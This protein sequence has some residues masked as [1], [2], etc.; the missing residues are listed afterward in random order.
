MS[1]KYT[2]EKN[3]LKPGTFYPRPLA[4][5]TYRTGELV[6]NISNATTVTESDVEAVIKALRTQVL[7]HLAD[8][9]RVSIDGVVHFRPRLAQVLH[10]GSGEFD[11][12]SGGE[13][14]VAATVKPAMTKALRAVAGF[15]KLDKGTKAPQPKS[16]LNSATKSIGEYTPGGIAEVSGTNLQIFD[17]QA[18]DEGIFFVAAADG[19]ETRVTDLHR[20][21]DRTLIFL[22]PEALTG[23]QQ[24]E[25][26]TRYTE[27][28][29][30]RA[31]KLFDAV[32]AA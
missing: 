1:I 20:N 31:G 12:Q 7:H 14:F 24:L 3:A 26:R 19:G 27:D 23:Q 11:P 32:S 9:N 8:G 13:L 28:G 4:I 18:D 6:R 17:E 15:E 22:I 5:N 2:V 29:T 16:L 30:L 25:V 21:G 10:S